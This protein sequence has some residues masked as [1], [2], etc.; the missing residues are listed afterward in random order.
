MGKV[1]DPRHLNLNGNKWR[2]YLATID[3]VLEVR[4]LDH[5]LSPEVLTYVN[6]QIVAGKS[7][8]EIMRFL[9]LSGVDPRW[10]AIRREIFKQAVPENEQ[11]ALLK[12]YE[13]QESLFAKLEEMLEEVQSKIDEHVRD[14]NELRNQ[15][16]Y[17]K[18]KLEILK[19]MA[20]LRG[21]RF[22]Q[23]MEIKH[24]ANGSSKG[25]GVAIIIQTNVPRPEKIDI[26]EGKIR[27]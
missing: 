27:K 6:S 24:L 10:L 20:D 2:A 4:D 5:A 11:E 22:E 8:S 14:E 1:L 26:I 16:Q 12:A 15:H 21:K 7:L 25:L 23:F 18:Y 3:T 9:G 17:Y 19:Q 13:E